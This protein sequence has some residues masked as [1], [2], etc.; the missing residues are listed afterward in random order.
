MSMRLPFYVN[1]PTLSRHLELHIWE[2][3][4]LIGKLQKNKNLCSM[5]YLDVTIL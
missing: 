5:Y 1:E 4:H 3:I 2:F